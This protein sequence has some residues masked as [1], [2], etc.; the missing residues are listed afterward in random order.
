MSHN[1]STYRRIN[2][3]LGLQYDIWNI[4]KNKILGKYIM[5]NISRG[6]L[7]GVVWQKI[8][9]ETARLLNKHNIQR[10]CSLIFIHSSCY[11]YQLDLFSHESKS[12][13]LVQIYIEYCRDL[14]IISYYGPWF[15]GTK[16]R[17][18]LRGIEHSA[19]LVV[20]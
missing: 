14:I 3:L 18:V 16:K 15:S 19:L 5:K 1:I 11:T 2:L 20:W 17:I 8:R 12:I 9:N 10:Q 6:S 13:R 4:D 7:A